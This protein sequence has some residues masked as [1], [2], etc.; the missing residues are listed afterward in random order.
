M[1]KRTLI[2]WGVVLAAGMASAQAET[3]ILNVSYDVSREL[4]KDINPGFIADWQK[5]TGE[6][7]AVSQSHGGSS[8]QALSVL[9]GLQADV[10]TM[11][12]PPDIDVLAEGKLV[13]KDWRAKFPHNAS[14]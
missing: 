4:Y 13:A 8:K 1:I 7:V 12:Q 2:A 10:V 3:S 14:P 5:K 11:N 9:N 6:K